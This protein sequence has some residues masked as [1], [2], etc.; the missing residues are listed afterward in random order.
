[1]NRNILKSDAIF[2]TLLDFILAIE[3]F[4]LHSFDEP[5]LQDGA[6]PSPDAA[7]VVEGGDV[8]TVLRCG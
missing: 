6:G 4:F 1:M 3:M 7:G 2:I 8:V 5:A